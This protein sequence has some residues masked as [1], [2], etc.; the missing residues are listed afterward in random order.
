MPEFRF[1]EI[2]GPDRGRGVGAALAH[3]STDRWNRTK[4]GGRH[5]NPNRTHRIYMG[6]QVFLRR[7]STSS[8]HESR[9]PIYMLPIRWRKDQSHHP[10]MGCTDSFPFQSTV[11]SEEEASVDRKKRMAKFDES[12]P[13]VFANPLIKVQAGRMWTPLQ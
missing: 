3:W 7:L 13:K 11:W 6:I 2:R 9:E 10:S 4:K 12:F 1:T 8:P 5:V